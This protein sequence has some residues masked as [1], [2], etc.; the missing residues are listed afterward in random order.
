MPVLLNVSCPQDR[1]TIYTREAVTQAI[2]WELSLERG[3][4]LGRWVP[5]VSPTFPVITILSHLNC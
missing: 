3:D 5:A 4:A 1:Q 2:P